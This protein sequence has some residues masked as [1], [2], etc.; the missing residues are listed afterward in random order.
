MTYENKPY[1]A[2]VDL[3][4]DLSMA[5]SYDQQQ[6]LDKVSVNQLTQ[7]SK[8]HRS[9]KPQLNDNLVSYIFLYSHTFLVQS[10]V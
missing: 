6:E 7:L 5:D 9:D 3:S 8:Y 2:G 1:D 10:I 4:Q